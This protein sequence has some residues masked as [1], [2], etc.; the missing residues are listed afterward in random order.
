MSVRVSDTSDGSRDESVAAGKRRTMKVILVPHGFQEHYTVG[1]SNALVRQGMAVDLVTADN[2]NP[3]LFDPRVVLVDLGQS[4]RS[5]R[6][7]LRKALR[8]VWYHLRLILF[9]V[10]RRDAAVHI[11]GLLRHE[12]MTG[13][14]QATVFRLVSQKYVLTVHN[15][16]PHDQHTPLKKKLYRLIYRLPHLLVVH[17]PKM[18]QELVDMFSIPAD[19]IMVVEH[20]LNDIVKDVGLDRSDCRARLGIPDGKLALLFFGRIAPYKGLD[21]L[22]AAFA[23][24]EDDTMLLIAGRPID[25]DYGRTAAAQIA[26]NAR[27]EDVSVFMQW[28]EDHEIEQYFR[29]AD[30]LVLPYR[31][32]DQSGVIFLALR[33]G[34]P[35]I[36]FDVGEMKKYVTPQ[37]GIVVSGGSPEDLA[38][39][40]RTFQKDTTRFSRDQILEAGGRYQWDNVLAPLLAAY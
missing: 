5:D 27:H 40:I 32:I 17:T 2:L 16:L 25:G 19:K 1:F 11:M 31:H 14:I 3:D 12:W 35:T 15:I 23:Q 13:L 28:I 30:A 6:T 24:L 38:A 34:I 39:A 33:F 20:G 36:A 26:S 37:T 8:F 9:V 29:A 7:T 18:K 21:T 10:S 22:L 4:T